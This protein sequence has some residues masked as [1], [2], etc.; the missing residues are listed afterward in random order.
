MHQAKKKHTVGLGV[1]TAGL[2]VGLK[3]CRM[4]ALGENDLLGIPDKLGR[5]DGDNEGIS[6]GVHS[7]SQIK[8]ALKGGSRSTH[9]PSRQTVLEHISFQLPQ[10]SPEGLSVSQHLLSRQTFDAHNPSVKQGSP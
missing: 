4:A 5:N 2:E 9:T 7:S 6:V 1:S 10:S 3:V 8:S